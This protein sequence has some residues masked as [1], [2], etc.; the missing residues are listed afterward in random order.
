MST[1]IHHV[2][3][4]ITQDQWF[5][6][7]ELSKTFSNYLGHTHSANMHTGFHTYTNIQY[8]HSRFHPGIRQHMPIS[9]SKKT[10]SPSIQSSKGQSTKHFSYDST[11]HLSLHVV[12]RSAHHLSLHAVMSSLQ[13]SPLPKSPCSNVRSSV[14]CLHAALY[15]P[16]HNPL[17]KTLCKNEVPCAIIK[18]IA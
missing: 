8:T 11:R 18:T 17:P 1:P 7:R 9:H 12:T 10:T 4:L 6:K 3:G 14:H 5:N 16:Q 15:S 13:S 2:G